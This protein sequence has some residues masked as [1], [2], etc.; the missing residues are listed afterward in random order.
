MVAFGSP[1]GK[2]IATGKPTQNSDSF[3][4][5]ISENFRVLK[6]FPARKILLI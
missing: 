1:R 5:T 6:K 2:K 3:D 4:Y